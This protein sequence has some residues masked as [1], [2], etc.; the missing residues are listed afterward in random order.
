[1]D[2]ILNNEPIYLVKVKLEKQTIAVY[3]ENI[4]LKSGMLLEADI[5]LDTRKI[6]EWILEPLY[7]I[8]GKF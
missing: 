8:S 4:P 7:T 6:Y 3:G 5:K 1:M 2:S